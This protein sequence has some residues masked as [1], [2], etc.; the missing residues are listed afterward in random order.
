MTVTIIALLVIAS[1]VIPPYLLR[2]PKK[3]SHFFSKIDTNDFNYTIFVTES[4][5]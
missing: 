1:I 3:V 2:N 5:N 4:T